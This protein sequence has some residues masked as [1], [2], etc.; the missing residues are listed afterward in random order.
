MDQA[1]KALFGFYRKNRNLELHIDCQLKLFDN[2]IVPIL[3]YG[4]EIWG[5]GDLTT[6]ETVYTGFMK[7]FLNVKKCTPHSMLYGELG[8][9]PIAITIK[10]RIISF[11]SNLLLDKA[12]ELS[13]KLYSVLYNNFNNNQYDF[14]WLQNV[15]SILDDV[16]MSNIWT[17]KHPQNTIWL[18]KTVYQKLQ[19]QYRQ[20]WLAA[21][22]ESPKCL[23]YR[24]IETEHKFENY[25]IRMPPN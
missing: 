4:C 11:W 22:N 24:I 7:Y 21:L 10:K 14:P 15:K 2:T 9:F 6:I 16:G 17:Y 20:S 23:N 8:R 19:G 1:R 3:T 5:Y 12:S 13:H 18:S 25:L